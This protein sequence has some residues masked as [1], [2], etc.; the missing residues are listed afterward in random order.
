MWVFKM[1]VRSIAQSVLPTFYVVYVVPGKCHAVVINSVSKSIFWKIKNLT[2][3]VMFTYSDW[4]R[5]T[6]ERFWF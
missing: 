3:T 1:F 5:V 2:F 6:S 4:K